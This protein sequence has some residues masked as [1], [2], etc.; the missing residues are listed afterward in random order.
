MSPIIKKKNVPKTPV[1][2]VNDTTKSP[3]PIVI[4]S[5][6]GESPKSDDKTNYSALEKILIDKSWNG[7]G[8]NSNYSHYWG[9][10]NISFSADTLKVFYP[11]GSNAPSNAPR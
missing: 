4:D 9:N 6:P 10:E 8:N 2:A 7:N 1:T 3:R 11:K 5:A